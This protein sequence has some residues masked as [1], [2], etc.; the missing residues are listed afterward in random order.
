MPAI[1]FLIGRAALPMMFMAQ[2]T[3]STGALAPTMTAEERGA[4]ATIDEAA[5]EELEGL[6]TGFMDDE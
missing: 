1:D 3:A 4:A 6:G 5:A 2:L